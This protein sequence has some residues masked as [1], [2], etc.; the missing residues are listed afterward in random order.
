MF[1]SDIGNDTQEEYDFIREGQKSFH[2]SAPYWIGGSAGNSLLQQYITYRDYIGN[3][4]G[5]YYYN[6]STLSKV[7]F[8]FV[9]IMI[10]K[11]TKRNEKFL[12]QYYTKVADNLSLIQ[13]RVIKFIWCLVKTTHNNEIL[14]N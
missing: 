10:L 11:D 1:F 13:G 5:S 9:C 12:A 14:I 6:S 3:N 8:E 2:S 4:S 7:T